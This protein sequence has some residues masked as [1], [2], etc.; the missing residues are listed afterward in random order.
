M[1][2]KNER[3]RGL[4]LEQLDEF[5]ATNYE[6]YRELSIKII[7]SLIISCSV[8][9]IFD[10]VFDRRFVTENI[11]PRLLMLVFIYPYKHLVRNHSYKTNIV[12]S[13]L[14]IYGVSACNIWSISNLR[15]ETYLGEAFLLIQISLLSFGLCVPKN[16]SKIGH[17]GIIVESILA[18]SIIKDID[19]IMLLLIQLLT[20]LSIEYILGIIED[21][22]LESYKSSEAIEAKVV[23]DPLTNA[24]NRHKMDDLCKGK[25]N[26]L[27]IERASMLLIDVDLFK[28]INDTYGHEIGD[29]VLQNLVEIIRAFV[30]KT[31]YIIRW[32]GEEFI[33]ILPDCGEA[34]A[35]EIAEKLR[36][37]VLQAGE[38]MC[39][40]SISIGIATYIGGDY[41][42]AI[43]Q[44]DKALYYAKEHGRNQVILSSQID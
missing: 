26:E 12:V 30:R 44:A 13:Y 18:S 8:F 11:L 24:F 1:A 35:Q 37:Q 27:E 41:H 7:T 20:F 10:C 4:D 33:I 5:Y 15:N 36:N 3:G 38:D 9:F 23:H 40:T 21:N 6:R 28:K 14:I 22:S 39:N 34:K 42:D 19:F 16:W 2:N 31:D 29:V 32:G 25:T 43:K 17:I